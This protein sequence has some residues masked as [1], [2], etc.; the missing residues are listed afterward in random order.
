MK[1]LSNKTGFTLIEMVVAI[2][3]FTIFISML[4]GTYLYIARAQSDVGEIRKVY[5]STRDTVE[6]IINIARESE[7]YYDC[8]S[9]V[10]GEIPECN[11]TVDLSLSAVIED[12]VLIDN[13]GEEVVVFT[14]YEDEG[15]SYV[16]V[17]EYEF[18]ESSSSWVEKTDYVFDYLPISSNEMTVKSLYFRIFP[19]GDPQENYDTLAYQYQ[20][21]VTIFMTASGNTSVNSDLTFDLQTT[22]STRQYD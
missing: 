4:A 7:V 6:T 18:S 20:P 19:Y 15:I 10:I 5:S 2:T 3:I 16:G 8:Y 21:H 22:V 11:T 17:K 9:E 13:S 14:T 1:I 12:L